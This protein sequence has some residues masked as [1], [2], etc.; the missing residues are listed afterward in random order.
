MSPEGYRGFSQAD[1][2]LS[3]RRCQIGI[4]DCAGCFIFIELAAR[5]ACECS[6]AARQLLFFLLLPRSQE[7][8][9]RDISV[10][11]RG[12]RGEIPWSD[13]LNPAAAKLLPNAR[14]ARS[15]YECL[16]RLG[17]FFSSSSVAR[18]AMY[19][20]RDAARW[21]SLCYFVKDISLRCYYC[22]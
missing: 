12:P 16:R 15:Y 7:I 9:H 19:S 6:R 3:P 11:S 22:T 10:D 14:A 20:I 17:R 2:S 8:S 1:Q 5:A 13:F 4:S 21:T 18:A